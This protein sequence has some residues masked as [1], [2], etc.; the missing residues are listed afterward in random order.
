VYC[1]IGVSSSSKTCFGE[2]AAD[3]VND[4]E[5]SEARVCRLEPKGFTRDE[6]D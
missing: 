1:P 3:E 2:Y 4:K 6:F 5:E